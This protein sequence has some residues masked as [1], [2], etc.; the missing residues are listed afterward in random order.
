MKNR[1][2][3]RERKTEKKAAKIKSQTQSLEHELIVS[4][5]IGAVLSQINTEKANIGTTYILGQTLEHK[6]K[7]SK[8]Q[9]REAKAKS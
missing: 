5:A 9:I 2:K 3:N 8:E 1:S 6:S 7:S 4:L